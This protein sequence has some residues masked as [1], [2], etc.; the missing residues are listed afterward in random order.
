MWPKKVKLRTERMQG[1]KIQNDLN[2]GIKIKTVKKDLLAFDYE[3]L[4]LEIETE[5]D[6]MWG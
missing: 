6:S 1:D 3:K 2:E 5:W 4:H